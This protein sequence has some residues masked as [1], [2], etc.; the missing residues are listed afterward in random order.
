VITLD[1]RLTST[2]REILRSAQDHG[3]TLVRDPSLQ[4]DI[5]KLSVLEHNAFLE[6]L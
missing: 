3:F 5:A 4:I 1:Q 2:Q 6:A